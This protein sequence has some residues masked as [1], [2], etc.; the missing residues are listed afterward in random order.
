MQVAY[1]FSQQSHD[2]NTKKLFLQLQD[3]SGVM[4][5]AFDVASWYSP[6][7][8]QSFM[9]ALLCISQPCVRWK[10]GA[11]YCHYYRECGKTKPGGS[12]EGRGGSGSK[13]FSLLLGAVCPITA[14][15][16]R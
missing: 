1:L 5:T 2:K 14:A 11:D 13:R 15:W 4:D 7:P 6:Q 10:G 3:A 9:V 8:E 16:S 12:S